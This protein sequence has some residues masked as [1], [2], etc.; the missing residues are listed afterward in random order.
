MI[1]TVKDVLEIE[2]FKGSKVVAGNK[3]LNRIVNYAL[4]M[5]VPDVLGYVKPN[6]LLITTLY[7]I[8]D[9]KYDIESLIPR[10]SKINLSGICIKP[11][12]YI[13]EIPRLMLEQANKLGFPII[14]LEEN[15]NLSYLATSIFKLSL[16]NYI[17]TLDFRNHVHESLMNLFLNGSDIYTLVNKLSEL[18]DKPIILLD[19]NMKI[20]YKSKNLKDTEIKIIKSNSINENIS[21]KINDTIYTE[22]SFV[23]HPIVAGKTKFGYLLLVDFNKCNYN[24]TMAIEQGSLLIASAFYKNNAVLEKEKSFQD[25]FIRNILNGKITSEFEIITRAQ[26]FGWTIEF[27]Q[28]IIVI[29]IIKTNPEKIRRLYEETIESNLKINIA[30]KLLTDDKKIKIIY[31]ED[32]LVLFLPFSNTRFSKSKSIE[33]GKL[34]IEKYRLEDNIS[35]GISNIIMNVNKIPKAY[36]EAK[37]SAKIGPILDHSNYVNHFDD[38]QIFNILS[39]VKDEKVLRDFVHDKIGNIIVHDEKCGTNFIETIKMLIQE[40]MSLKQTSKKLFIHYNT[41]R[42]RIDKLRDMGFDFEK[43]VNISDIALAITIYYWL[44]KLD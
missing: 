7:P 34:I 32:S 30:E 35:L 26:S 9:N 24:F 10:L 40:N 29:K 42:Y 39:E 44:N 15:S 8:S 19:N 37:I 1:I 27:P 43:N 31:K 5:E 2:E 28:I 21:I 6:N 4:L 16:E 25:S 41:L 22:E 3:G 20:S 36:K 17:D 38:Y 13:K 12:R 23:V 33:I 11:G 18:L 14:K